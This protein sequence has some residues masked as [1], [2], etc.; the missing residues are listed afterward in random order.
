MADDEKQSEAHVEPAQMA[1]GTWLREARESQSLSVDAVADALHLDTA[2]V[3]ALEREAFAELGA[4]VF[5]KGHLRA[6][7]AHLGL[8]ETEA[9]QR[10][11]QTSGITSSEL[12]E[13]IVQ[14]NKPLRAKSRLPVYI[15]I[16]LAAMIVAAGVTYTVM[17]FFA[18]DGRATALPGAQSAESAALSVSNVGETTQ[19]DAQSPVS[20]TSSADTPATFE[21]RLARAETR[22][23]QD[24]PTS[25]PVAA[26][27]VAEPA[28]Q[29]IS[30]PGIRLAFTDECWFEVRDANG[31]RL[32]YGTARD[33]T[34]RLVDGTRPLA[35][36]LGVADA[37]S[38]QVDG[39]PFA[40]SASMRRGRAARFSVR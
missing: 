28:T 40:I 11:E 17:Q 31:V 24:S 16:A 35:V 12:P 23:Q 34:T 33:G 8:D 30:T 20:D 10:F 9:A 19:R 39:S 4:T 26:V 2:I 38:V 13:L 32:A 3:D 21:Q 25:T 14:Y 6:V 29:A 37:V 36:T 5:A 15:G 18:D 27:P 7:A 1:V 22:T